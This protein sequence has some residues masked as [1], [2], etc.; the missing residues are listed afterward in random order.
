MDTIKFEDF[1]IKVFIFIVVIILLCL[2]SCICWDISETEYD[3]KMMD[4]LEQEFENNERELENTV[5]GLSEEQIK[6]GLD[7][8]FNA[9]KRELGDKEYSK[10]EFEDIFKEGVELIKKL[11]PEIYKDWSNEKFKNKWLKI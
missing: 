8:L 4:A 7:A 3:K 9:Y 1:I 5:K 6:I 2:I 11:H 10:K